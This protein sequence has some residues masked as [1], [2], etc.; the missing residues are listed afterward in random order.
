MP[1]YEFSC[2]SCNHEFEEFTPYDESGTYPNVACPKCGSK[3]K[4]KLFPSKM[5]I[6]GP[7]SSKMDN[8]NYRAGFNLEKAKGERRAAEAASHMGADPFNGGSNDFDLGEG[9]HHFNTTKDGIV[10]DVMPSLDD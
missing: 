8:F 10:P 6:V 9:M 3:K 4:E 1:V 5:T 7:T 2:V